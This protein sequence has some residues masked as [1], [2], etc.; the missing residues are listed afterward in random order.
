MAI[1]S[2]RKNE[3][4]K[5][6][7]PFAKIDEESIESFL[8]KFESGDLKNY[9]RVKSIKQQRDGILEVN[10]DTFYDEVIA[11]EWVLVMLFKENDSKC[12]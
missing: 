12:E 10:R 7:F 5:Y 3:T 1:I 2:F 6:K 11:K 8:S 4:L 9:Y